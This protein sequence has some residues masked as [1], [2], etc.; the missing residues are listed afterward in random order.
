MADEVEATTAEAG[1]K[2]TAAT[3]VKPFE[4]IESQEALDR[5]IQTRL[6]REQ[7]KY[8]D[9]DELKARAGK[10]D[11]IEESSKTELQK[12]LERA[13]KA[14]KQSAIDAAAISRMQVIAEYSIPRDYQDLVTGDSVEAM[15]AQAEKVQ[16]LVAP[17]GP[18]VPVEGQKPV[19]SP[20]SNDWL[21][22]QIQKR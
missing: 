6:A 9:Y 10:Y 7:A 15:K 13:E 1:Q 12:M 2:N 8:S 11:E 16:K 14:E 19:D 18:Y 4:A 5:I 3:E 22:D 20:R 17:R 21:R